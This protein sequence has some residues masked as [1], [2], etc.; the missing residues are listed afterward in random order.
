MC[1][2]VRTIV[3]PMAGTAEFCYSGHFRY[4]DFNYLMIDLDEEAAER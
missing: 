3:E 4:P 1:R 2:N